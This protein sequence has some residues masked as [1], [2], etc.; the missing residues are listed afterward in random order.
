[1]NFHIDID[2]FLNSLGYMGQ[3]LLG[4]FIVTG[5]LILTMVLLNL[6]SKKKKSGDQE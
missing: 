2:A 5:F 3:G 4:I 6:L 1:M